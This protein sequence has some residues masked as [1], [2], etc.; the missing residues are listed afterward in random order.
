MMK[1]LICFLCV[2]VLLLGCATGCG[3]SYGNTEPEKNFQSSLESSAGFEFLSTKNAIYTGGTLLWTASG[4]M[5]PTDY[6]PDQASRILTATATNILG[7]EE[8]SEEESHPWYDYCTLIAH[9]LGQIDGRTETNSL[10]A[11]LSSYES[12]IRAF[13]A[14]F[15]LTSDGVLVVRRDFDQTSYW[16]LE[17]T[18]DKTAL[19]MDSARYVTEKINYKYTPLT[20][21]DLLELLIEHEDAYLITDSKDTDEETVTAQF[22]A[23][24]EI[25]EKLGHPEVLDRVVVQIYHQDMLDYIRAV[26]PFENWIFTLYMLTNPDLDEIGAFCVSEGIDVVTMDSTV[27]TAA[28]GS[29][30]NGYGLKIYTHTLNRLNDIDA[31]RINGAY[32]VYSDI[33]TQS[34]LE[35]IGMGAPYER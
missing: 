34:D 14:D 3:T 4:N 25:A 7:I 13:E 9:A 19:V 22:T 16:N 10:E 26:Y 27:F 11:F 2:W 20:A 33:I 35:L 17:Q 24:V 28:K 31:T 32:G 1:R 15:Q 29:I 8:I 21:E 6:Q 18:V 23:L 30:L 5:N 12:G